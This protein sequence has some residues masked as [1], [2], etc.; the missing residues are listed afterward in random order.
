MITRG[1]KV[2]WI[3]AHKKESVI[4]GIS[5]IMLIFILVF[6]KIFFFS[7][8]SNVY[9]DRLEDISGAKINNDK[10]KKIEN[11]LSENVEVEKAD[12]YITGRVINLYINVAGEVSL[13]T[14]KQLAVSSVDNF[15]SKEQELY[16]IQFYFIGE[17]ETYPAIGYKG[18]DGGEFTWINS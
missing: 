17:S 13:D 14:L 11:E 7:S 15:S 18:K 16:D 5:M 8:S 4:I 3:Q 9:G 2:N 1:G 12:V 10:L 6:F